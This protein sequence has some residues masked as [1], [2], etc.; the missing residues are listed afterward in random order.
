MWWVLSPYL[1]GGVERLAVPAFGGLHEAA[2]HGG[3]R[4]HVAA[5]QSAPSLHHGDSSVGFDHNVSRTAAHNQRYLPC[6][7]PLADS[8]RKRASPLH[9][10]VSL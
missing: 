5:Q 8:S 3:R 2:E 1:E 10:S 9:K 4:L 6:K 7:L